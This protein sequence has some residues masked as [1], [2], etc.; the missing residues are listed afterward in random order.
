MKILLIHSDGVEVTKNKEA[1]SKPQE[2]PEDVI[3]ID[4][5]VLVAYVSVEDQDS[6]DVNLISNQGA[7]VIEDAILQITS[8]PE[9]IR[10]KN[11]EIRDYNSKIETGKVKG[12]ERNLLEIIKD[13]SMYRVDKVLVYPWAHLSKFLSNDKNAMEVCPKIAKCLNEKGI[14]ASYSPFGWYKSFKINCI[15]HEVA[16]MFRYVKLAIKPEEQV[17]T[18]VIKIITTKGEEI[19]LKFDK[20]N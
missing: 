9:K 12:K 17:K 5:L 1:T 3:K 11:E 13:R 4:G 15:G 18:S 20:E 16:E 6:Y 8:F 2:F 10:Q 7:N 14:E 19:D